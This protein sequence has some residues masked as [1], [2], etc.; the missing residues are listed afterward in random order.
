MDTKEFQNDLKD[1]INKHSLEN[2]SDTPDIVIAEFL[3]DSL[4][5][6]NNTVNHRSELCEKDLTPSEALYGFAAWITTRKE[7][8]VASSKDDAAVWARLVNEFCEENSLAPP[9]ENQPDFTMPPKG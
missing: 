4:A 2:K 3:V 1:L 8:V 5:T 6:F 9:R 7:R